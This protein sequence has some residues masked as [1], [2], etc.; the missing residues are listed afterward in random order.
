ME[1]NIS[2]DMEIAFCK[3]EDEPSHDLGSYQ[4]FKFVFLYSRAESLL[5]TRPVFSAHSA[6]DGQ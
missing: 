2:G 3:R 6:V 1:R 5:S 4:G